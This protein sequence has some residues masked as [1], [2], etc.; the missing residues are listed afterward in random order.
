LAE[1]IDLRSDTVTHPTPR[2]RE[3]MARAEVGDDSYRD[4]PTVNRL[5]EVAADLLGKEA[6]L[7]VPSG[8]M[9]N[10]VSLMTWAQGRRG[11]EL[12]A[13]D[14]SHIL[15]NESGAYASVAGLAVRPVPSGRGCPSTADI[16]SAIRP[17]G[18]VGLF[19]ALIALENTNNRCGGTVISAEE[20]SAV[21]DVAARHNIPLHLDGARIW[22]AAV[23]LDV[24]ARDLVAPVDSLSFCFS[25]G[26]SCPIG[27][28]VVGD[29]A[30]IGDARRNRK[31]VGGM[32]RQVGVLAAAGLVALEEM[33]GRLAEDH[34]NA[35]L[36][37]ERLAVL[38]GVVLDLARVQT[39]IVR[40]EYDGPNPDQFVARLKDRGVWLTGFIA[41]GLRCVTHYGIDESDV[42][43]AADIFE[44]VVEDLAGKAVVSAT[45]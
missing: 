13:G 27:S 39:N 22:N 1:V 30:F 33:I 32:M 28:M 14:Q 45:A 3:A 44:S 29:R 18:P 2:M 24:P 23:A 12:I 41:E 40:F 35:R 20:T 38:P 6:A 42:R 7:F 19:T 31:L 25:K 36:L 10:L 11:A 5:Q 21:A 8:T 26:L 9:G 17:E 37:A 15:H 16:E 43:R 4:D 34:A